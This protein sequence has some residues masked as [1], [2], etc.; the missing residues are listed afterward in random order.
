V[1]LLPSSTLLRWRLDAAL[2]DRYQIGE[3]I[4]RGGTAT[5]Y[6]AHE[7]KHD[8]PVVLKVLNPEAAAR[9]GSRRFLDEIQLVAQL[10]HP[11]ILALID[12]GNADGLLYYVMPFVGGETLRTRLNRDRRLDVRTTIDLLRSIADALWFAHRAN[13]VHRDL[14]PENI[15][16]AGSHPYLLDFGIAQVRGPAAADRHTG[17]GEAMGTLGYMAPEQERGGSTDHRVDVYALGLLAEELLT[18]QGPG[19]F[20]RL[21]PE[22]LPPETPSA[23]IGLIRQCQAPD[24]DARPASMEEVLKVLRA[25]RRSGA[26]LRN[27]V[28]SRRWVLPWLAGV[29][30]AGVAAWI[31]LGRVPTIPL[32]RLR[33]PVAVAPFSNETGDSTLATLGRLAGDWITQG[34]QETG[35]V[36]VVPWPTA[37]RAVARMDQALAAGAAVD[38]VPIVRGETGAG[39]VITGSFYVLND[40]IRF[41]AQVAD[42]ATGKLLTALAPTEAPR[43]SAE[44][45]IRLLRTRVM[46]ALAIRTERQLSEIP[47]LADRPPTFEAYRNFDRALTLHLAQAYDSAAAAFLAAFASDTTFGTALLYAALDLWNT[48]SY[49]AADSIL[50]EIRRRR[51]PLSDY[52]E[53]IAQFLGAILGG[54]GERALATIRQAAEITPDT[55][56]RYL[57][58]W[59]ALA[60]DRPNEALAALTAIN[61]VQSE[62]GRWPPYWT[63]LAHAYHLTGA[64]DA[65]LA[66]LK[67]MRDSLPESR[68]GIVFQARAAAAKGDIALVDSVLDATAALPPD[69]YWSQGAALVIVADELA[70]HGHEGLSTHYYNRGERWLARQLARDSRHSAHRYWMG[71]TLYDSGRWTL[72]RPYFAS[73]MSD[74]P[75]RLL[76]RGYLALVVARAG[77]EQAALRTLGPRP[78]FNPGEHT[79]FLAR[80]AAIAGRPGE[81][82][83][84]RAQAAAEGDEAMP[85][86]HCAAWRELQGR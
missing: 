59:T 16:V 28:T 84:L 3:E 40:R 47:G 14:K 44:Q 37:L 61:P 83:S 31:G 43:D 11:H 35:R 13:V 60:L 15:L 22:S 68:V 56:G 7:R 52:H 25:S 33:M 12:S 4:G 64:F 27:R 36:S 51:L 71:R 29:A 62:L 63:K 26:T 81:A 70:A 6:L 73:L 8:R 32:D 41:Q 65:E 67:T 79:L 46:A 48:D 58:G 45:A 57:L 55:R 85:W 20:G 18:G 9:F 42:A 75:E 49:P 80:L 72:A 78:R 66:A 1:T 39:T 24:P 74:Y 54:Q 76:Y 5:V 23:L 2:S 82:A 77:D 17:A 53:Q 69:T 34:L 50:G 21:L 38:P 10:S 30:A 19:S 86:Y